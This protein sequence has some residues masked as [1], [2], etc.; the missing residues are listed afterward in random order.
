[1]ALPAFSLVGFTGTRRGLTAP[2]TEK[3]AEILRQLG[4][5][6]LAH[7]CCHG[8]D[9]QAYYMARELNM[10]MDF[11]PSNGLQHEWARGMARTGDTVNE[12][13]P[14]LVRNELIVATTP[15]LIATPATAREVQRSGTWMTIRCARRLHRPILQICPNGT[16]VPENW[17]GAWV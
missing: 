15:I 9:H 6:R 5:H 12:I 14:P 3:V 11:W 1:M 8:A 2:Q 13:R 4:G 7:G 10:L 17:S 16:M